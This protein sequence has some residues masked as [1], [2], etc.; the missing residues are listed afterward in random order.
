MNYKLYAIY[1]RLL[2]S[3]VRKMTGQLRR[4]QTLYERAMKGKERERKRMEMNYFLIIKILKIHTP[5]H[6]LSMYIISKPIELSF[7]Y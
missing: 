7:I 4:L 1:L 5:I 3:T 2:L 6:T